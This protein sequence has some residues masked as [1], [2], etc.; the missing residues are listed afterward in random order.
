MPVIRCRKKPIVLDAMQW[1][2]DNLPELQAW[3]PDL[4]VDWPGPHIYIHT[5]EGM[6]R[7]ERN[8]YVLKGTRGEYWPVRQDI[9]EDTYDVVEDQR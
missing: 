8:A 9:F 2:G 1:T 3:C 5:L 6:E 4:I 7:V